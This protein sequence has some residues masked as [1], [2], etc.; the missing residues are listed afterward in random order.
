M[1]SDGGPRGSCFQVLGIL[2]K[3]NWTGDSEGVTRIRFIKSEINK[4]T[5]LKVGMGQWEERKGAGTGSLQ[6]TG[7]RED[8]QVENW[9]ESCHI[10]CSSWN[11]GKRVMEDEEMK[12]RIRKLRSGGSPLLMG[13]RTAE[14]SEVRPKAKALYFWL[15]ACLGVLRQ[16]D[17]LYLCWFSGV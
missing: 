17:D 12:T 8:L 16:Q 11:S 1:L 10:Q 3:K 9:E 15:C 7:L 2:N 5:H 6:F 4:S 14:P 13:E